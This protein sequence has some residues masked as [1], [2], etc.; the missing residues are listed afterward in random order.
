MAQS[1]A[2]AGRGVGIAGKA[3]PG[4]P[5]PKGGEPPRAQNGGGGQAGN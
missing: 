3:F 1:G 2:N 4:I 5:D